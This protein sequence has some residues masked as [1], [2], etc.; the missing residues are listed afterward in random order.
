LA[1]MGLAASFEGGEHQVGPF[2]GRRG[3]RGG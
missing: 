2:S 1:V 3:R